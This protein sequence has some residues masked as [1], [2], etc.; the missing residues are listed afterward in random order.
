MR[1]VCYT[2]NNYILGNKISRIGGTIVSQKRVD[3]NHTEV[4]V[5]FA[6]KTE[7][8]IAD[9]I[10]LVNVHPNWKRRCDTVED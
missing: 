8:E 7:E 2:V 3:R 6:T 5:E 9:K 10:L 4:T 1:I